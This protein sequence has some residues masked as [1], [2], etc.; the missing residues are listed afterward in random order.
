VLA[1]RPIKSPIAYNVPKEAFSVMDAGLIRKMYERLNSD[2]RHTAICG[3]MFRFM[4]TN[5]LSQEYETQL[6]LEIFSPAFEVMDQVTRPTRNKVGR[7]TQEAA[8]ALRIAET[9]RNDDKE[10]VEVLRWKLDMLRH[11]NVTDGPPILHSYYRQLLEGVQ[12][13]DLAVAA[14]T[15]QFARAWIAFDPQ[16]EDQQ[17][18]QITD[19][20]AEIRSA[21]EIF[22]LLT[23]GIFDG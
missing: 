1:N 22:T 14:V 9:L 2:P 8:I 18:L 3:T 7:A 23:D 21:R 16:R 10:A 11:G 20:A 13:P 17:R 15:D 12:N 4:A 19:H 5:R 6:M